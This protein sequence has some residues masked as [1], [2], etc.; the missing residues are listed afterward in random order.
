[1]FKSFYMNKF[2]TYHGQVT[3]IQKIFSYFEGTF[4]P[5]RQQVSFKITQQCNIRI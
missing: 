3:L 5:L 4:K 2:L 1:M